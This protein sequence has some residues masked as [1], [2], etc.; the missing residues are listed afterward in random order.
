MGNDCTISCFFL[1]A[2]NHPFLIIP[3]CFSFLQ[4]HIGKMV[5]LIHSICFLTKRVHV[6]ILS[7]GYGQQCV[8]SVETL[9]TIE[10]YD[11]DT[12]WC[13]CWCK[14]VNLYHFS[15]TDSS[16]WLLNEF[17]IMVRCYLIIC[18]SEFVLN[19]FWQSVFPAIIYVRNFL[20]FYWN[21]GRAQ[22]RA[23]TMF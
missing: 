8:W 3:R 10:V 4:S 19:F 5:C 1:Y 16:T 11:C 9:Q 6:C 2:S 12:G 15:D 7:V 14:I 13:V 18:S 22:Q 23:P 17:E 21:N 20:S